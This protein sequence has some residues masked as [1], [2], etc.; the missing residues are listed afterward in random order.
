MRIITPNR[1]NNPECTER[2]A[3]NSLSS[4]ASEA[5]VWMKQ[6]R[7]TS[8]LPKAH[9]SSEQGPRYT[10]GSPG[11]TG[12]WLPSLQSMGQGRGQ[13]GPSGSLMLEAPIRSR[14]HPIQEAAWLSLPVCVSAHL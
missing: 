13:L 1:Q 11:N 14:K 9:L 2:T 8:M 7:G 5:G 3:R 6:L 4:V 12:G 10:R